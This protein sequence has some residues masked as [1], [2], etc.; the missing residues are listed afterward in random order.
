M[1]GR[2]TVLPRVGRP[3]SLAELELQDLE[4][5][6]LL[7]RGDS[8]VDWHRLAFSDHAAVDRFLRLNEF[9][10]ESDE[11]MERLEIM[12]A[13]SVEYLQRVYQ[14]AIP[15]A[16][17]E[18]VAARDL[19]LIASRDG[20]HQ[21]WACVVLKAMHI[22]HHVA[23]RHAMMALSISDD[24]INRQIELKVMKVVEEMRAG[25][26]PI[27]EFEWSRK[28]HDSL[29]T[30]LLAKRSTLAANIYDK[31]RFRL[32]VPTYDDLLPVVTLL[33]RQL[34][35][36]NYVVPGESVNHL[37]DLGRILDDDPRLHDL[38][39]HLQRDTRG[40]RRPAPVNE[41]SAPEYRIINFVADLPLRIQRMIPGAEIPI[42]RSHVIFVLTEFQIAD[43]G[44]VQL[45]EIG[46]SSH[47]AYKARQHEKVK[48][49]LLR[50]E[51]DPVSD[52]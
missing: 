10:P 23:G 40:Q 20:D 8:V 38:S 15:D 37:I 22:I 3:P 2:D 19:F 5:L 39:D 12:R 9:D 30:K 52:D 35:P 44:T 7:L 13:D 31:L 6:R 27:A 11:E 29:I 32:I 26:A 43:K 36:F 50:S 51:D 21:K 24:E 34:I 1:S 33:T 4:N 46:Q 17:A 49:R 16:V 48:V 45:N 25:G 47:E 41:F 42:D 28:P 18:D 14:V